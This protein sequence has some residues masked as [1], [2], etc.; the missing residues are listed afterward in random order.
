MMYYLIVCRKQ[1][2]LATKNGVEKQSRIDELEQQLNTEKR[3]RNKHEGI[4]TL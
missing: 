2:C 3:D 1:L 4:L